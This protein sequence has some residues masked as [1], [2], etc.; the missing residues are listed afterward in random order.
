MLAAAS[1]WG[2]SRVTLASTI[3]V[4]R[5]LAPGAWKEEMP[6]PPLASH[7]DPQDTGYE[8]AHDIER[9]IADYV[10]WLRARHDR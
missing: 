9:G 6:L 10:A 3:G 2:V 5:G 1:E 7:A 8:P 4:Y